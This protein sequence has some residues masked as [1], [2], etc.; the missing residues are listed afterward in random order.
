MALPHVAVQDSKPTEPT[1]SDP[2]V[3][4]G[5]RTKSVC[6]IDEDA[7]LGEL[8]TKLSGLGYQVVDGRSTMP[9]DDCIAVIINADMDPGLD[10]TQALALKHRIVLFAKNRDFDFRLKAARAGVEAVL[11]SPLDMVDLGA[12]LTDFDDADKQAHTILIVDDDELAAES[13][14]MALEQAGMHTH[15]VTDATKATDAVSRLMPDLV[16]MDLQMPDANG[17]E[18]AQIIRQSRQ[19]LSLPIVFLSAERDPKRQHHA[20]KVGGDDFIAKPVDLEQLASLVSIRAERAQALRQVMERDSLTGLLNHARFKDRLS[21]EFERSRRTQSPLAVCLLDLD[22][23]KSVNDTY[24]H[25]AGDRVLQTLAHSLSGALRRTDVVARYGGEEFAIVLLD[26]A[27]DDAVLV[28]DKIRASFGN[29]VFDAGEK[30]FS[31]TLSVG[32]ANVASASS[33]E[34]L[35]GL[36]DGALYAAKHAGRNR[37]QVAD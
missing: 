15:V 30:H 33:T 21:A 7:V 5:I 10:L 3:P 36:A 11:W 13:Y 34:S 28:M 18:I 4:N 16:L 31:V 22:H 27:L 29:I 12:W 32:V 20:R 17:L 25:Q 23:F 1:R 37:V 14:A 2:V 26:T 8:S 19:H 35:I 9:P 6:V 24:G